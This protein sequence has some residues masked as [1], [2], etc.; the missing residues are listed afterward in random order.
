[1]GDE[2]TIMALGEAEIHR[3]TRSVP[4]MTVD[5][6][7]LKCRKI[8]I[9]ESKGFSTQSRYNI[10]SHKIP[11]A[12]WRHVMETFFNI[13]DPLWGESTGHRD[14]NTGFGVFFDVRTVDQT[15]ELLVIWDATMWL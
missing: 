2:L 15:V 9:L 13:T 5:V 1:M 7:A 14:S 4:S 12:S 3:E 10:R 8:L 6:L 11:A